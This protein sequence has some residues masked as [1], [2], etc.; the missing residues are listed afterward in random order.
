MNLNA[1]LIVQMITFLIFVYTAKIWVWPKV[2]GAL[3]ERTKKIADGLA[4]AEAGTRKLEEAK[5]EI[6][7]VMK[8]AREQAA[9]LLAQANKRSVEMV[10]ES[11]GQA[12]VEGERLVT[13][14]RAQIQQE[15]GQAREALRREVAILAVAGAKQILEREIDPKTHAELLERVAKQ[16]N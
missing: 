1:T 5:G 3:A 10:E 11:R 7:A 4:A 2:M 12:R 6:Q 14:A 13:A 16:M 9:E 15:L 8:Q